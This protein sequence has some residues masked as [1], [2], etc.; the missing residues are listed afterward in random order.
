MA[1]PYVINNPNKSSS[2]N[3]QNRNGI[4]EL[5]TLASGLDDGN[6]QPGA[7]SVAFYNNGDGAGGGTDALVGTELNP[8]VLPVGVAKNYPV[9]PGPGGTYDEVVWNAD[10]NRLLITVIY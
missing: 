2:G 5:D 9:I 3:V 7:K 1:A 6:I 4:A 8:I 10:G